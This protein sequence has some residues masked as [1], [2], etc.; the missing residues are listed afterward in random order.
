M[1][2]EP[3]EGSRFG[4]AAL[5]YGVFT[6]VDRRGQADQRRIGVA[7]GN[8]VLDIAAVARVL[9]E[10]FAPLV[11]AE[12]L[13]P[14]MA[15][16]PDMWRALR[17]RVIAWLTQPEYRP[18][19]LAHVAPL[20]AVRL[21]L[22]FEVADFV[23]FFASEDHARNVGRMFRPGRAALHP[24][25]R[26]LPIG[27]HG[28]SGSVMVSGAPVAR[29]R[30]Q[31]IPPDGEEP[32]FEPTRKLDFEAEVG[33]VVGVPTEP[34]SP[35]AVDDFA[36]HVFGV[37]LVN[38]WSARD[39]QRYEAAPLGPMLGKSF[40][41]SVSPWVVPLQALEHAKVPAPEQDPEPAEYLR[42][43]REWALDIALEVRINGHVVSQPPFSAMYW[44][45]A[46]QLAHLTVN[47]AALRTGDLF[48]SGTVSGPDPNQ[49]G[50]LL[51]LSWDG[52]DPVLLADGS[53]RSYLLD[54]DVVTISATAP[55]AAGERIFLGE[56]T[57][58][59][60]SSRRR[61]VGRQLRRR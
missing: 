46:Q 58:R 45:P 23:D 37:C 53:E 55:G 39:I 10:E 34:A 49:R 4:A 41:T 15:A 5:P 19:V 22:P 27:Y 47:G 8:S 42:G 54:E 29:P 12:V 3:P 9:D 36:E 30:G 33:F 35:V 60:A 56:V 31:F 44:T 28:R 40:A 48:A 24:N 7:V 18:A 14:L 1:W 17:A 59:V 16:G 38:D 61:P 32:V 57:G 51:E 13:N 6:R 11:E 20:D 43:G 50:C 2:F 21:H 26:R 25:W 52:A